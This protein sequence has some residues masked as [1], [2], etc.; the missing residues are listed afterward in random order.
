MDQLD[1]RKFAHLIGVVN[2]DG[3]Q[4]NSW[5]Y[6]LSKTINAIAIIAVHGK[7]DP[8][9]NGKMDNKNTTAPTDPILYIH[10]LSNI[11]TAINPWQRATNPTAS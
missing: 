4:I 5:L 1:Q 8:T 11:E 3:D 2:L 6:F 7:P 9:P 10:P